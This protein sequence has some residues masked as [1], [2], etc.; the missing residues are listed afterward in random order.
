MYLRVWSGPL[1]G[2]TAANGQLQPVVRLPKPRGSLQN[3]AQASLARRSNRSIVGGDVCCVA[4][5]GGGSLR[6]TTGTMN[7]LTAHTS[8]SRRGPQNVWSR[9]SSHALSKYV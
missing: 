7:M 4:N 6:S 1:R 2:Q 5:C 8:D 9:K 3:I